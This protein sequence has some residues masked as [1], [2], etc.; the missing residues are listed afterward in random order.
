MNGSAEKLRAMLKSGANRLARCWEIERRDGLRLG[1]TDHDRDLR[2]DELSFEAGAGLDA[3]ALERSTGLST[4]NAQALG[5]L[6]S[7]RVTEADIMAGRFDAARVRQW[8]VDW[9]DVSAR[10]QMFE[11]A[12][13]EIRVAGGAFEAEL[14]G[15]AETLNHPL[16][17]SFLKTCD[18]DLGDAKCGVNVTDPTFAAEG[19][20]LA[21][22]GRV[23]LDWDDG[24]RYA[25]GWFSGG[26]LV[27]LSG[28]NVGLSGLVR[29]DGG[30]GVGRRLTLWAE[31]RAE[32]RED[33][34]FRVVAGCDKHLGTCRDKFAN[35]LNFR[36]FAHMPGEDWVTAYPRTG[37]VHDGGA[38]YWT[39]IRNEP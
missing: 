30:R 10:I 19:V 27:W 5:A 14:R 16:G 28:A 37:E 35:V 31:A 12:L 3:G 17:R 25:V 23:H 22:A 20:V 29:M 6:R 11:G 2:F 15:L 18:R 9:S 8:L 26:A 32:I 13:G 21:S 36:G 1:F 24:G 4:D 38:N 33:D 7:D 39:E 34:R